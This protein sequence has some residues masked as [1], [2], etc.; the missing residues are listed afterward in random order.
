MNIGF[1]RKDLKGC[2][3]CEKLGSIVSTFN[4]WKMFACLLWEPISSVL[5]Y[6][7]KLTLLTVDE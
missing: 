1:E 5:F 7:V 3:R 2:K 4:H 6:A